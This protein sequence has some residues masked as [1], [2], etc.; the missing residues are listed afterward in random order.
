MRNSSMIN[1]R[2]DHRLLSHP[3]VSF[4]QFSPLFPTAIYHSSSPQRTHTHHH[5]GRFALRVMSLCFI[6]VVI[7]GGIIYLLV[8]V[9]WRGGS[10][11][12]LSILNGSRPHYCKRSVTS[13]SVKVGFWLFRTI[14]RVVGSVSMYQK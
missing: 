13:S 8:V 11:F 7:I 5:M 10:D 2:F 12:L 9:A 3:G 6:V 1:D 14:P 4:I